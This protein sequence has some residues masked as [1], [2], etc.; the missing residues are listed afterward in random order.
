[1]KYC[2]NFIGL[3]FFI[4]TLSCNNYEN[5]VEKTIP[6]DASQRLEKDSS[7]KYIELNILKIYP[8]KLSCSGSKRFAN[9]Y[10]A[11]ELNGQLIYVFEYCTKISDFAYDTSGRYVQIIDTSDILRENQNKV[12]IFVPKDFELPKGAKYL[13]AELKI[14]NES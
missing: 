4:F 6:L 3:S 13:F 11:K 8:A 9:L 14:L 5:Y 1:M 12:M 10:I 2:L 7:K